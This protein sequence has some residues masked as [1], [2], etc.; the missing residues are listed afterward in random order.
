MLTKYILFVGFWFVV[1]LLIGVWGTCD[2]NGSRKGWKV[3]N[4]YPLI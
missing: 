4:H 2:V 3:R 1:T